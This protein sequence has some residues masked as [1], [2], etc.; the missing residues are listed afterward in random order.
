VHGASRQA[1]AHLRDAVEVEIN[2]VTDNP[3]ILDNGQAVSGGNFHGQPLALLLD[4][5][6]LAASELGNIS[7]RRIFLLLQGNDQGLPR[8]LLTETGLQ[9]GFMI[10]QY[11]SAALTCENKTLCFPASADSIPTSLGQED[12]VSMGSISA[13]KL[14]RILDNLER[15][16]AVEF[17]CAAQGMDF[18]RPLRSTAI[19]EAVHARIRREISHADTD[20]VFADDL[21]LA[22]ALVRDDILLAA[23]Q[24]CALENRIDL[25]GEYHEAFGME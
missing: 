7:D 6:A 17:T 2:A 23:A 10:S 4:Y 1:W 22:E 25:N 18:R 12:H 15:I 9:S 3:V 5:A 24:Q 16:L 20:R 11:T 13:R 21:A 19:L 14:H 8:L